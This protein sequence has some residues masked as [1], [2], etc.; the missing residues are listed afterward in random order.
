M[1]LRVYSTRGRPPH[2]YLPSGTANVSSPILHTRL[3]AILRALF[4]FYVYVDLYIHKCAASEEV[5]SPSLSA[6]LRAS[7]RFPPGCVLRPG[8]S[9]R[10]PTY[11]ALYLLLSNVL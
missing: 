1:H 7:A 8:F 5:P 10:R 3:R 9:A 11:T 2:T 6:Y 4:F